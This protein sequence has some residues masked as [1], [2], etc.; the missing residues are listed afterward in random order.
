MSLCAIPY[1]S[2]S[3]I[4][5]DMRWEGE[6]DDNNELIVQLAASA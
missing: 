1:S 6:R 2:V 4:L 5:A 3:W